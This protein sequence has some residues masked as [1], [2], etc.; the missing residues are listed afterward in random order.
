M[1]RKKKAPKK[2]QPQG[3]SRE[4]G[5]RHA[6]L[7]QIANTK[8][9]FLKQRLLRE[10]AQAGG[11]DEY[12]STSVQGA[13]QAG[14]TSVW[15]VKTLLRSNLRRPA[16]A[17]LKLLDVGAI[18][19]TSYKDEG[20]WIDATYCDLNPQADHVVQSDMMDL[21]VPKPEDRYDI[22][23]LSLVINYEG[24]LAK[25]GDMIIHVHNFLLPGGLLYI[26]LPAA[27]LRNSRYMDED[28]FRSM[29]WSSPPKHCRE[30]TSVPSFIVRLREG[31]PA[32]H[33]RQAGILACRARRRQCGLGRKEVEE[34]RMSQGQR[35][36]EQLLNSHQVTADS[37]TLHPAGTPSME[38]FRATRLGHCTNA[39][40]PR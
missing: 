36:H 14:E 40:K 1:A 38:V 7:K 5:E 28:R 18:A 12:Q 37:T 11:L 32:A 6:L 8:D 9:P 21:P 30:L 29:R 26:V 4:I 31:G 19:G 16:P 2:K 22:C 35:P 25:R 13:A 33:L 27:C 34:G 39:Y 10:E 17:K 20:E 24:D 15:L 3:T 23:C